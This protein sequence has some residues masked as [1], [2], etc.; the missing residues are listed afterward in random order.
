VIVP[1]EDEIDK[2]D[3]LAAAAII[4]V[5]WTPTLPDAEEDNVTLRFATTPFPIVVVFMPERTHRL[6]E[7][8][9]VLPAAEPAVPTVA[10]TA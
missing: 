9:S 8:L 2:E 10:V 7:H 6:P 3:V 4:P 1:G 5:S